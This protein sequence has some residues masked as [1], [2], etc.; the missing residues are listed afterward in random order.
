MIIKVPVYVKLEKSVAP[1]ELQEI[2][3]KVSNL[4]SRILISRSVGSENETERFRQKNL[5][6]LEQFLR[7]IDALVITKQDTVE[8]LRTS[9]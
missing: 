8:Y 7:E 6:S 1:E 2:T 9:K 5:D 4:F 3:S